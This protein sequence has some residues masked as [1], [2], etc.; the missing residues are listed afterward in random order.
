MKASES[1]AERRKMF[2][3]PRV[4]TDT[5]SHTHKYKYYADIHT[6]NLWYIHK[7]NP[8]TPAHT[9]CG[10]PH[11]TTRQRKVVFS[12]EGYNLSSTCALIEIIAF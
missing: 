9:H 5:H 2:T 11:G 1:T 12:Q 8:H 6:H 4:G 3:K 7:N 10:S